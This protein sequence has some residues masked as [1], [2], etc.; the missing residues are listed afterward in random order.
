MLPLRSRSAEKDFLRATSGVGPLTAAG[1]GISGAG[2]NAVTL[3]FDQLYIEFEDRSFAVRGRATSWLSSLFC[4]M[5]EAPFVIMVKL[6]SELGL[7]VRFSGDSSADGLVSLTMLL[8]LWIP[9]RRRLLARRSIRLGFFLC[10][11]SGAGCNLSFI[12]WWVAWE[13]MSIA[14]VGSGGG[15]DGS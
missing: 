2:G 15:G 10:M 12:G 9:D 14:S 5:L 13:I 1:R 3:R 8:R 4:K 11:L 7:V 6:A